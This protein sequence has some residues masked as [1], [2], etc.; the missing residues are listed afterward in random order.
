LFYCAF[1]HDFRGSVDEL[2]GHRGSCHGKSVG[3]HALHPQNRST[4]PSR[5]MERPK[6]Q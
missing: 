3:T 2:V 1:C 5:F 6:N 4:R